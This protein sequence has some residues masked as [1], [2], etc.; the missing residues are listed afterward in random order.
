[1]QALLDGEGEDV[2]VPTGDLRAAYRLLDD[3]AERSSPEFA[4]ALQDL[5][6]ML[7]HFEGR[8]LA[9]GWRLIASP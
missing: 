9:D 7:R 3:L 1:M 8:T 6:G 2:G 5:R 4:V